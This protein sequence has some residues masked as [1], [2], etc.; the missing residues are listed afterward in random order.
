MDLNFSY[1]IK[2]QKI[3]ASQMAAVWIFNVTAL[4]LTKLLIYGCVAIGAGKMPSAF[5]IDFDMGSTGFYIQLVVR[6]G[7]RS[8]AAVIVTSFVLILL[9][10][11]NIGD[12]SL[13]GN[14]V[15]PLVL[16]GVSVVFAVLSVWKV[17]KRD[18]L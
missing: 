12:Y 9:T 5:E 17:E 3:L 7:G 15:F 2:R 18:L 6:S 11:A 8:Q 14:A 1:P 16:V 4:V 10:Q 13:A